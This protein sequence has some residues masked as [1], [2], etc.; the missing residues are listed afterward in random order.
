[1]FRGET[2]NAAVQRA[3]GARGLGVAVFGLGEAGAAVA[4][5][6]VRAG[7]RVAGWDPQPGRALRGVQLASSPQAAVAEADVVLVLTPPRTSLE[8]ARTLCEALRS[9]QVYADCNSTS[10][11][12]KR[13]AA[14]VVEPSGALFADVA[15]MAP[16]P[17]RGLRTPALASGPGAEVLVAWL[18]PLGMPI[19]SLGPEVGVAAARKLVRSVFTKGLAAAALEALRAA[20]AMDCEEQVYQDLATTLAEADSGLLRRLVE[21]S[22]RHAARRVDEMRACCE[23]L[24]ELRVPARVARASLA[25]LEELAE[26][27]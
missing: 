18:A 9:G 23:M 24:D 10:P 15:L 5:D 7:V 21:G 3:A 20:R 17:G 25:W 19:R 13:Q 4:E 2:Y 8:V 11:A 27:G 1:M 12:V 26:A 6:L 22:R 14:S 16:V